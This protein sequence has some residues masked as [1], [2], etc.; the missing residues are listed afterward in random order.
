M[1]AV[2]APRSPSPSPWSRLRGSAR[3]HR[4]ITILFGWALVATVLPLIVLIP[5]FSTEVMANTWKN[6]STPIKRSSP[7][8]MLGMWWVVCCAL[9][10]RLACVRIAPLGRPVVP[11][12][13]CSTATSDG[14]IG[15]GSGRA[16]E[17]TSWL[18]GMTRS[19]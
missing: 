14:L 3:M 19:P 10:D 4:S 6:G 7:G 11:P 15:T 5:P 13:Y 8:R 12:V 17:A 16:L 1:T 2:A 18:Y 9:I